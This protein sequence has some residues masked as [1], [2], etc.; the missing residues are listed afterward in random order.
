MNTVRKY[1]RE[2]AITPFVLP[3]FPCDRDRFAIVIVSSPKSPILKN[4]IQFVLNS[5]IEET[6]LITSEISVDPNL[7]KVKKEFSNM[8]D[9]NEQLKNKLAL[10]DLSFDN[11]F[12][13][14]DHAMISS[15]YKELTQSKEKYNGTKWLY[16][17][18][19]KHILIP[20]TLLQNTNPVGDW[21]K[22]YSHTVWFA[23]SIDEV[24][25]VLWDNAHMIFITE[26]EEISNFIKQR[27]G[28][29]YKM[30][31]EY[32]LAIAF[33]LRADIKIMMLPKKRFVDMV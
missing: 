18:I 7:Y 4:L 5:Y 17:H 12:K 16:N 14:T 27:L 6:N 1:T 11:Q 19:I 28:A 23:S 2:F 10:L 26:G 33:T 25:S 20:N 30:N 22:H 3:V 29:D 13:N 15:S 21:S 9:T 8:S 31:D 32:I 24:P